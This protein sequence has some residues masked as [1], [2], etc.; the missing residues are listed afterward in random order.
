MK[1][2]AIM[3]KPTLKDPLFSK[4]IILVI[5]DIKEKKMGLILNKEMEESASDIWDAVNP[6]L[7]IKNKT[8]KNGGD[9][10]GSICV[11]HKLKE[12]ADKNLFKDCY[13]TIS[14][15][16]IEKIIAA[17]YEYEMYVGYCAW[18]P[19]DFELEFQNGL[20]WEIEP[21]E[22]MIFNNKDY[23]KLKKEEQNKKYLDVLNIKMQMY[24]L[25]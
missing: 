22:H 25:N 20:W 23:W 7:K 24:N 3:A 21:D 19:K 12:Y 11:I 10:Y 16:K 6:K 5:D 13:I 15:K 1:T 18:S 2:K 8:L 9:V 4:S 17:T 14:T